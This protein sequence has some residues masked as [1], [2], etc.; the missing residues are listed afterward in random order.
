MDL[1]YTDYKYIVVKVYFGEKMKSYKKICL[2]SSSGGHFEQIQQLKAVREK[3]N[4]YYV[5]PKSKV[6]LKMTQKKYLLGNVT[7]KTKIE[8]FFTYSRAFVQQ[9]F[10]F[11]KEKPDIVI[12]TGA[13]FAIPTSLYAHIFKKKLIYIE[14]FARRESLNVTG[15]FLYKY[16]DLFVVQWE[17][18]LKYYPKAI[19]G[20]WI[21]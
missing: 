16:A 18:L 10:V 7:R 15:K 13:G 6:F 1:L 5:L 9:F 20:G 3:Y 12:T 19:Y 4:C 11:L 2:I 21:Y 17:E 8:Y 14:S